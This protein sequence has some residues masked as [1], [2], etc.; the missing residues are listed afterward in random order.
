MPQRDRHQ[1]E[2]LPIWMAAL[3]ASECVAVG[4]AGVRPVEWRFIAGRAVY[5]NHGAETEMIHP[6]GMPVR[7]GE[8]LAVYWEPGETAYTVELARAAA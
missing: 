6:F 2:S 4:N 8:T 1:P 3:R 7:G 5:T